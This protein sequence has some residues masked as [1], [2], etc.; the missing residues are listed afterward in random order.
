MVYCYPEDVKRIISTNMF[1]NDIQ[2]LIE[3]ADAEI[4]QEC[5]SQTAGDSYVKKLSML[6]TAFSIRTKDPN[7]V[8]L[9]EYRESNEVIIKVWAEE[10]QKKKSVLAQPA[11][12]EE[13][14]DYENENLQDRF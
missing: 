2:E 14:Y 10:I 8:S 3:E 4:D 5:G 11:S 6:I 7:S 9:G 12:C 13:T 1:D